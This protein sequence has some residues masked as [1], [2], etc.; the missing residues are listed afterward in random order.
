M[1]SKESANTYFNYNDYKDTKEWFDKKVNN[2]YNKDFL[3]KTFNDLKTKYNDAHLFHDVFKELLKH[4]IQDYIL[5]Y[6]ST[7]KGCRYINY[8]LNKYIVKTGFG[9]INETNFEMFKTFEDELMKFRKR[10]NH[11]CDLYYIKEDIYKKM[12]YLYEMYDTLTSMKSGKFKKTL[13]DDL[14]PFIYKFKDSVNI[15]NNNESD[16]FKKALKN[17]K[18]ELNRTTWASNNECN[19]IISYLS[20]LQLEPPAKKEELDR[21]NQRPAHQIE[22]EPKVQ[23]ETRDKVVEHMNA[24]RSPETETPIREK[25]P[26]APLPSIETEPFRGAE[27][28]IGEPST[29][30]S[31]S[32]TDDESTLEDLTHD[33]QIRQQEEPSLEQLHHIPPIYPRRQVYRGEL[34]Y[35]NIKN[36]PSEAGFINTMKDAF[37]TISEN[38]DPVPL[39]GVSGGMGALFLLFRFTPVGSFFGGRRRRIHQIPSSFRGFPPGEFPIFH[40]Y[41]GGNIG[42]GPMNINPLAE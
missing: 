13:C 3:E 17:L 30:G 19:D 21:H 15:F 8:V 7:D 41:E 6:W 26:N 9:V 34:G 11:A 33:V 14:E 23:S 39:M 31:I 40:E 37:S 42:Y 27:S 22:S 35:S 10:S 12:N 28:S 5:G 36:E 2:D 18:S 38:V 4:L 16:F 25:T 24:L 20:S 32:R 29:M 1:L